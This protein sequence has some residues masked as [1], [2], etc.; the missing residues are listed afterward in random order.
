MVKLLHSIRPARAS[1]ARAIAVVHDTL[2]EGLSQIVDFDDVVDR[3]L[4][5]VAEVAA[6]H[7]TTVHPKRVG[8]FGSLP[9]QYATPLALALTELVTNAVEHGLQDRADGEVELWD[10]RTGEREVVPAAEVVER[11]RAR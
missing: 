1:D 3:V 2:S 10:R 5:L 7:T 9:S 6:G 11:L 4:L 8:K